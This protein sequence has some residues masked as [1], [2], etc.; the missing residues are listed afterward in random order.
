[1]V[2]N[3]TF[4]VSGADLDVNFDLAADGVLAT[5]YDSMQ[6]GYRTDGATRTNICGNASFS[7]PCDPAS[8]TLTHNGD[9]NYTIK[10]LGGAAEAANDNRYLFRVGAGSDRETRVYLFGDFPASPVED[11][12][13]SAE[14]CNACH[15]PE[16]IDVHGGYFAA[17][18]GGEPCL[19]CHGVDTVASLGQVAHE[20]HNGLRDEITYP[21]Y[22]TNCSVCHSEG[23]ELTA[24]N[25][26]PFSPGCFSCHGEMANWDFS[27]DPTADPPKPD[28]VSYTHL[29]LPT[30][31]EV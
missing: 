21:T 31:R 28:P 9:G 24:A 16:G 23:A 6:R 30:N 4:T 11:L 8:L 2:S 7:D 3:V 22:M 18:D 10:V 26:L 12:V 27:G 20:Y 25:S 19:V 5:N 17:D 14:S 15:G 29:T 13:I 1:M